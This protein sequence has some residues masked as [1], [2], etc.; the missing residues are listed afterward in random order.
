MNAAARGATLAKA[1]SRV[2]RLARGPWPHLRPGHE[3]T[4]LECG[5][6][7][8]PALEAA[9]DRAR[10]RVDLETYILHDDPSGQRIVAAL[11]RAAQRGVRVRLTIDGFGTPRLGAGIRRLLAGSAVAVRVY[12]PEPK[13]WSL[14]RSRL[15]RLHRKLAVVDAA[16]VFVGGINLLDDFVDPNHGALER[17]RLD[18]AVSVRG[19]LVR[20]A[21][22]A[23]D[24]VWRALDPKARRLGRWAAQPGPAQALPDDDA[25]HPADASAAF[26][27]QATTVA[28]SRRDESAGTDRAGAG[29][30]RAMLLLRDNFRYRRAIEREYLEAISQAR[31]EIVVANAYFFPGR[32]L[33]AALV[34]AARRGVRVTLL[35]QGRVEY[36]LQ[37]YA[38]QALYDELLRGGIALFEYRASFLH[39]KV[40]LADDWVT[41]GS[42]NIDPFSL[43]LAR[44]ANVVVRDAVFAE[45]LRDRLQAAIVEGSRPVHARHHAQRP[46]PVRVMNWFA[47]GV[48]RLGVALSGRA[49]KY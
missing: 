7:F 46:W 2:R 27:S 14:D 22:Q 36:R 5:Q 12:R 33:R 37:H 20:E 24:E 4:L 29:G 34:A 38:S 11:V 17:P 39:A 49:S 6:A 19:P 15:R 13:G 42:S 8:F 21:A 47:F 31:R 43:L 9:I 16:E 32:R 10:E 35:L 23:V 48:L 18:Y 3:V 1:V 44:E 28:G 25:A 41:V 45:R 40:A 30:L 26:A